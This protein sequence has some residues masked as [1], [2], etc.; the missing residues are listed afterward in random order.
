MAD[1]PEAEVVAGDGS[2]AAGAGAAGAQG[3]R[4]GKRGIAQAASNICLAFLFFLALVPGIHHYANTF[5]DM[6]WAIG[7]GLMGLLSLVRVPPKTVAINVGTISATA[8]MMIVP[9][10]MQ[11]SVATV[12]TLY[13]V[14]VAIEI[15]GVV[16]TQVARLYLGRRFGLLPANRGIVSSGPFR[17]V[18]HPI[19]SGWLLLSVGFTL[20][21]PSL[22]NMLVILT[23][24]PFMVWRVAQEES[25]LKADAGYRAY[26]EHVHYR[27]LPFIF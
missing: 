13:S 2:F 11:P 10:M 12:G 27:I 26:L 23:V 15:A 16:L 24:L 22:R 17:V 4:V 20:I 9:A 19:Y 8:G 5:A 6:V 7:A 3:L 1:A 18:R 21:Y 25:L 14:G